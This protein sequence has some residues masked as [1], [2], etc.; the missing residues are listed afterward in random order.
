MSYSY[1]PL[2][3]EDKRV[4]KEYKSLNTYSFDLIILSNQHCSFTATPVNGKTIKANF[5]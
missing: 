4:N 2:T 5:A 1:K 3:K